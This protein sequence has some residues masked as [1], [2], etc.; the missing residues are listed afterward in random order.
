VT[1]ALPLSQISRAELEQLYK[2]ITRRQLATPLTE[3]GLA[4]IGR[5]TLFAR[6]GPLAGADEQVALAL[7]ELAL[8]R[9]EAPPVTPA[10]SSALLTWTDPTVTLPNIRTTTAVLLELFGSAQKSV[11]IAGYEFD[12]GAVIFEPLYRVMSERGVQVS[13][14]ADF[15]PAPSPKSNMS[16]YLTIQTHQ[17]LKRNWPFGHPHPQ[18]YSFQ[19]GF[20]FGSDR[21]LHAKCVVVDAKHVLIGSANFTKRGHTR[22]LEVGVRLEDPA[23]AAALTGQLDRLVEDGDL[24]PMPIASALVVAT[25]VGADDDSDLLP[26]TAVAKSLASE[27]SVSEAARPLLE[28]LIALNIPVPQVD[29]DVEGT[30][31]EVIGRPELS[32]AEARIAVLLPEQEASRAALEGSG[33]TCFPLDLNAEEFEALCTRVRRGA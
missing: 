33:W 8:A 20:A 30:T 18:L 14:Y 25:P 27:L 6:L 28:R 17:F 9:A 13:I 19:P 23:L 32:W 3:A 4:S 10:R 5:S 24:V 26:A 31:G 15:R 29:M 21:S 12:H 22:N 16:A 1:K 11:V 2:A 7:I